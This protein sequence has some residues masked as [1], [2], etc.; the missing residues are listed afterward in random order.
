MNFFFLSKFKILS[1]NLIFLQ[2]EQKKTG[3]YLSYCF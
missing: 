2:H 1:Q 3:T